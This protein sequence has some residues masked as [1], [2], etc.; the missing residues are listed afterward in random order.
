MNLSNHSIK[1]IFDLPKILE[2]KNNMEEL[3]IKYVELSYEIKEKSNDTFVPIVKNKNNDFYNLDVELLIK[4]L[5]LFLE[6]NQIDKNSIYSVKDFFN[7]ENKNYALKNM[8]FLINVFA[9]FNLTAHPKNSYFYL[10]IL[11]KNTKTNS[12]FEFNSVGFNRVALL[13]FL[14]KDFIENYLDKIAVNH[15][16]IDVV[17]I[18]QKKVNSVIK[19]NGL[20]DSDI[21]KS[22]D[23]FESL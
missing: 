8:V 13:E 15:S 2:V 6:E 17:G 12:Y 16:F 4:A 5:V 14:G 18:G 1:T 3:I 11:H 21:H 23:F 19:S 10:R 20:N 9:Y 22:M 7:K